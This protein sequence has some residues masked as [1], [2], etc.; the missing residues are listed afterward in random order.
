Y[1]LIK[2]NNQIFKS[3]FYLLLIVYSLLFIDTLYQYYFSKNLLGFTYVNNHN[4]RI[5]SFF[6]DDE[7]LGS[8]TARFFPLLL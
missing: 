3:L 5:T 4:F 6:K 7:V 2:S 1:I 8:Y